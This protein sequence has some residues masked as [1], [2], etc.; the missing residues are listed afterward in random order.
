MPDRVHDTQ[1]VP[2]KADRPAAAAGACL[3]HIYP[4]GTQMGRRY[5]LPD[6]PTRLGRADD[7]DVVLTDNAASRRHAL[8]AP[9]PDGYAVTD[10]GSTNGTYV[11]DEP[12]G[13]PRPLRDGDY[14]RVGGCIYRFLAGGNVEAEY[15]EEIYRLTVL[16]GLTG[17]HN[18]RAL[19]EFLDRE[20]SRSRRYARPLSVLLLDIDHFKAVNDARG[21]LC[22]DFVLRG[23]ADRVRPLARTEDLFAR[24]GGEEFA[25]ALVETPHGEAVR[26]AERVRAAVATDPFRCDG[27][28][29]A[30]TVSVGVATTRGEPDAS[31]AG[32]LRAADGRLYLAKRG[33]RNRVVGEP[34]G[35]PATVANGGPDASTVVAPAESDPEG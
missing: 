24:Y 33:G 16:D 17:A 22:G 25:L 5:P 11:N 28:P 1:L 27:E 10:L 12:V 7:S 9:A 30:V 19:D 13:G 20:V 23:L 32:L 15:H 6:R 29:V 3:V 34:P 31:P 2:R 18:R 26:A 21:H 8:V 14:L 4:P 35:G